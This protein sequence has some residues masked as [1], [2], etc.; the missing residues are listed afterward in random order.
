[1]RFYVWKDI[2]SQSS[3]FKSVLDLV[4]FGGVWGDLK[5][6]KTL[7]VEGSRRNLMGKIIISPR[8]DIDITGTDLLS[9]GE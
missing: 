9:L 7:R 1:M 3:Y 8:Y 6:W 5:P 2:V 4:T